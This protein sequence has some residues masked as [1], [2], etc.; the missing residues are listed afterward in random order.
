MFSFQL[1]REPRRHPLINVL[2]VDDPKLGIIFHL[3][4]P[5]SSINPHLDSPLSTP[6]V[7]LRKLAQEELAR[8]KELKATEGFLLKN[9]EK[10]C[11]WC[12]FKTFEHVKLEFTFCQY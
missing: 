8:A 7:L 4:A 2:E 12:Y 10:D 5:L 11:E 3:M 1:P 6:M 9:L